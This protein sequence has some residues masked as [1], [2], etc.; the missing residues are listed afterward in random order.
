MIGRSILGDERRKIMER[1]S[2]RSLSILLILSTLLLGCSSTSTP[3]ETPAE[4]SIAANTPLVLD[5]QSA[6]ATSSISGILDEA[7]DNAYQ[8]FLDNMVSYNQISPEE[9]MALLEDE[10][11]PFLLDVR[12][13]SEVDESGRIEGSVVIPLRDLAKP[14]SIALLPTFDTNIIAYCGSGWRCTIAMTLLE[15]LGWRD[16]QTLG[17]GSFTGWVNAGYPVVTDPFISVPLNIA[18]PDPDVQEWINELLPKLPDGFGNVTADILLR[19][20]TDF[21][22]LVII[23]VRT[24]E[25]VAESGG[26]E[27]TIHIPLESFILSKGEWPSSRE[28]KILIYS[29][30]GYRSTIA[31]TMLW[32]YGYVGVASLSGGFNEWVDAGYPVSKVEI[33]D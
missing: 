23:D 22:D 25:E 13:L 30:T 7:L 24:P 14:E 32:T 28:A 11:P 4:T 15:A 31:M 5:T 8:T 1:K 29:N 19:A 33:S 10:S 20:M 9:L 3:S 26:I 12:S 27:N 2:F 21:P 18:Q 17:E 16:V 6:E